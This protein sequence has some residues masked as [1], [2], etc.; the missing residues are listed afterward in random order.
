MIDHATD[1]LLQKEK[2]LPNQIRY[3]LYTHFTTLSEGK[4]GW[5]NRHPM[6]SCVEDR[7]KEAFPNTEGAYTCF[8]PTSP[9]DDMV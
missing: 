6:P 2:K 5:K 7:I 4:L 3:A 8:R 9:I 1:L